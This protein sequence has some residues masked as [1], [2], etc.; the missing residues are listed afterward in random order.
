[1]AFGGVPF[2][3]HDNKSR[4]RLSLCCFGGVLLGSFACVKWMI[5][6]VYSTTSMCIYIQYTNNAHNVMGDLRQSNLN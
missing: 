6:F 1:M 3:S 2:D 4:G 5:F